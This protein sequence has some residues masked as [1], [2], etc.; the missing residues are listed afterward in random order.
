MRLWTEHS[1]TDLAWAAGLFDGEGCVNAHWSPPSQEGSFGRS[2]ALD[3]QV[4]MTDERPIQRL[5]ALF[6][7]RVRTYKASSSDGRPLRMR[8]AWYRHGRHA[9]AFLV[10]VLPYLIV[11][12]EV[13]EIGIELGRGHH[14][15]PSTRS[16]PRMRR[17]RVLAW[18]IRFLNGWP[19][20]EVST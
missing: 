18:A 10:A 17:R 2:V 3:V 16:Y 8:F 9:V 19:A 6:G 15:D 5:A 11:K 14:G 7:G 1:D 12:R 13:A 20:P 4:V